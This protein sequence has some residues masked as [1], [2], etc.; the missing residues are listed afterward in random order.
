MVFKCDTALSSSRSEE[1]NVQISLQTRVTSD[2]EPISFLCTPQKAYKKS[3]L[4]QINKIVK[5]K[6]Q[7]KKTGVSEQETSR[8]L[9]HTGL[10]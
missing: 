10:L 9:Q 3:D 1:Q 2:D 4:L 8:S 5:K 6:K 7:D